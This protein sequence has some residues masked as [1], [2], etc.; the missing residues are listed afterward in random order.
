[1]YNTIFSLSTGIS[2]KRNLVKN[3]LE[4]NSTILPPQTSHIY[5]NPSVRKE[6]VSYVI[7]SY[8]EV[9]IYIC[10]LRSLEKNQCV[11]RKESL[12]RGIVAGWI[13]CPC[14]YRSQISHS[15]HITFSFSLAYTDIV[16]FLYSWLL[17]Q[18]YDLLHLWNTSRSKARS[19]LKGAC[20]SP[21]R[22]CP[23]S[24]CGLQKEHTWSIRI[25]KPG[26]Y[27]WSLLAQHSLAQPGP[28]QPPEIWASPPEILKMDE[29][30][31]QLLFWMLLRFCV[32]WDF[33]LITDLPYAR[34]KEVQEF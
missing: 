20:A 13:T 1:M 15:N 6:K 28:S 27:T 29:K 31:K 19:H 23:L 34:V 11:F 5:R 21:V 14:F 32:D 25:L 22:C 4:L 30:K 33:L 2:N 12:G 8:T 18:L 10:F 9:H 24:Q 16:H 17:A 7:V 3:I 26:K